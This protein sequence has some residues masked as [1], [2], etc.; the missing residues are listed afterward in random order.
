MRDS[1]RIKSF[2]EKL[3][4][5]WVLQPDLRLGQLIYILCHNKETG[6][7][8]QFFMEDE[9]LEIILKREIEYLNKMNFSIS[10]ND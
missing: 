9:D 5:L 4:Q 2:I 1:K 8:K 3:E 10:I 7:S 6:E